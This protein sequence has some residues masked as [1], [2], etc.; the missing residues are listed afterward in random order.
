MAGPRLVALDRPGAADLP[1][2]ARL[3]G[4]LVYF[5]GPTEA[6]DEFQVVAEEVDRTLDDGVIY[7]VSPLD[8]AHK[9]EVEISEEQEALLNWLKSNRIGRVR[10]VD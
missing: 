7:I 6:E 1:I 5:M 3:R 4:Q 2:S 8:T 10:V 9:T